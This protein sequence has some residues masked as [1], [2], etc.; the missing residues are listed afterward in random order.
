MSTPEQSAALRDEREVR[1]GKTP[2]YRV[3]AVI[4]KPF[5]RAVTRLKFEGVSNLPT[6]GGVIVAANHACAIDP[7]TLAHYLY[8]ADRPARILAKD[9]LFKIPVVRFFLK[10]LDMIPVYRGSSRAKESVEIADLRLQQGFCIAVFPEGTLT[11]DPT[12]WPMQARTGVARMALTSRVPVVPVG[13][14]GQLGLLPRG[15]K[16]LKLFPRQ[17][18]T[19]RAG[20]PVDLSDLYDKELDAAVLREATDRIMWGIT[21]IVADIRGEQPPAEFFNPRAN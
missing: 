15:A 1:P 10:N 5:M 12:G 19:V 16:F 8:N 9:S 21:N 2:L 11:A 7:L 3:A 17:T 18:V 4:V 14:W 6:E 13:Q 20:E